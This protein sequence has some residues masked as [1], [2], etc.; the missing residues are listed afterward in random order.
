[1]KS[2]YKIIALAMFVCACLFAY[3]DYETKLEYAKLEALITEHNEGLVTSYDVGEH[4]VAIVFLIKLDL[5]GDRIEDPVILLN[6][7]TLLQ[8]YHFQLTRDYEFDKQKI[9]D[10][11]INYSTRASDTDPNVIYK[12]DLAYSYTIPLVLFKDLEFEWE[13]AERAFEEVVSS[14]VDAPTKYWALSCQAKI[15]RIGGNDE[16]ALR[17]ENEAINLALEL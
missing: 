17:L 1:M 9:Y 16:K 13:K 5:I 12:V 3:L 11:I 6:L 15:N 10:K 7:S 2:T 14:D 4:D 8:L